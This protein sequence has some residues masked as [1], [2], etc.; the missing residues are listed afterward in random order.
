MNSRQISIYIKWF[1][2]PWYCSL[3]EV[4]RNNYINDAWWRHQ[5]ETFS[6]LLALC[7]GNP[8][9]T[10]EFPSQRPVTR[11]FDVFFDLRLKNRLSKHWNRWWFE[12]PSRSLWRHC[13]EYDAQN[14]WCRNPL[15]IRS[16]L[17]FTIFFTYSYCN[18]GHHQYNRAETYR[19]DSKVIPAQNVRHFLTIDDWGNSLFVMVDKRIWNNAISLSSIK[20][21][22]FVSRRSYLQREVKE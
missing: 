19:R 20:Y 18:D 1:D 10:G 14:N 4:K 22:C 2:R 15:R 16:M 5:M 8:P 13:N 12:N 17:N 7:E 11:S 3:A 21:P 9:V 6:V